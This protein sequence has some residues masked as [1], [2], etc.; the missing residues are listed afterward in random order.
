MD[1][2]LDVCLTISINEVPV[3][4]SELELAKKYFPLPYGTEEVTTG[5]S[6]IGVIDV[7]K[8]K[9]VEFTPW[10]VTVRDSVPSVT[11]SEAIGMVI[12]ALPFVLTIAV[13][14]RAP[15]VMSDELTPLTV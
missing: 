1:E 5:E 13:P 7:S 14:D 10:A 8:I 11:R 12:V 4:F 9:T 15:P 2:I 6:I 3:I